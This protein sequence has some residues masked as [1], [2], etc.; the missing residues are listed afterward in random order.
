LLIVSKILQ[1]LA[2]GTFVPVKEPYMATFA[3][4]LK[5]WIF[6]IRKCFESFSKATNLEMTQYYE[7][8]LGELY[9]SRDIIFQYLNE[10]LVEAKGTVISFMYEK[11]KSLSTAVL[12]AGAR[13]ILF[14]PIFITTYN[15]SENYISQFSKRLHILLSRTYIQLIE[16]LYEKLEKPIVRYLFNSDIPIAQLDSNHQATYKRS[17][18]IEHEVVEILANYHYFFKKTYLDAQVVNHFF[19]TIAFLMD[20][21]IANRLMK[22]KKSVFEIKMGLSNVEIWY[23]CS[24]IVSYRENDTFYLKKL[25]AYSRQVINVLLIS[26]TE[27]IRDPG[28][29]G[30]VCPLVS[31]DQMSYILSEYIAKDKNARVKAFNGDVSKLYFEFAIDLFKYSEFKSGKAVTKPLFDLHVNAQR[32]AILNKIAIPPRY[33]IDKLKFLNE[34][35]YIRLRRDPI[36]LSPRGDLK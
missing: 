3:P 24:N 10:H 34:V 22:H 4:L 20:G 18:R 27:M 16:N 12:D 30:D 26:P 17:E 36:I 6:P 19:E 15:A 29:I 13:P 33:E 31:V 35:F 1:N 21:F 8:T 23:D 32:L 28:L 14:P 5:Q 9:R 11:L 2:N 7:Y 25:F